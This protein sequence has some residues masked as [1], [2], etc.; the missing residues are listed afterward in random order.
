[1]TIDVLALRRDEFPWSDHQI[2]LNTAGT[3]PLPGRAVAAMERF[4]RARSV[5]FDLVDAQLF[6]VLTEARMA[7]ANLIG[8]SPAEIALTTNTSYGINLAAGML[9]LEAGDVVLASAG[10]F[11]AN[12]FPWKHLSRRG[13]A[14]R[15]LPVTAEG[16]PDEETIVAQLNDPRVK[17]LAV[18]LVQFHT[19]YRVD[20]ERLSQACLRTGTYLIVDAIQALGAVPFD[21]RKTPVDVLACGAQK[22]LLGPWG[23]GFAYV[24]ADLIPHLVPSYVGWLSFDGTSD[25]S[26]ITEYTGALY[27]DARR[28]ELVTLPFQDLLGMTTSLGL[29]HDIGIEAIFRHVVQLHEPIVAWAARRGC[30]MASPTGQSGSGMVCVEPIDGALA[31]P[32]LQA[33]GVVASYREGALRLS[34]HCYTTMDEM[35]RVVTI[36]D[37]V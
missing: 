32:R 11:P 8:A 4:T 1:M 31:M 29:L 30:R 15:L 25:F 27:E 10:E 14:L 13:I 20:L 33:N 23:A 18:S 6:D 5:P 36:L 9:P 16:W 21:V 35:E 3:G 12:V 22:W 17:V 28:Y 34:P 2:Y 19:G 7:A 37:A 26:Q 24:R